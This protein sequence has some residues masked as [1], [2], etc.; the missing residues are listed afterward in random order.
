MSLPGPRRW[1]VEGWREEGRS[2]GLVTYPL[3][4]NNILRLRPISD[5]VGHPASV[6]VLADVSLSYS[7]YYSNPSYHTL[8]QCSP[9]PPPPNKVSAGG[10]VHG[11]GKDLL[12]WKVPSLH[13]PLPF[14]P[15]PIRFQAV[16]FSPASRPPLSGPVEPMGQIATPPCLLIGST[17]GRPLQGLWIGVGAWRPGL[18]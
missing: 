12:L 11:G 2:E 9:N 3:E 10:G 4:H 1:E 6:S 18:W 5:W 17:S 15:S 16:S 14:H 13:V 7:H 8:S